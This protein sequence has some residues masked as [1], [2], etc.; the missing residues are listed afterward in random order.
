MMKHLLLLLALLSTAPHTRAQRVT[1]VT[2]EQQ[3]QE[4]LIQYHLEA[5][6]PL[7][8]QLYLSI[9]RGTRWE[10]PLKSCTGDVGPNVPPGTDKRIRWEVLKEREL[11]GD[12]IVFKVVA[13]STL[14][15]RSNMNNKSIIYDIDGNAY[16]TVKI[17]KRIWMADNLRTRRY[18]NGD[19]IPHTMND[20]QWSSLDIGSWCHYNND[21]KYDSLYA[22]LYN[23]YVIIDPRKVCPV[24][25]HVPSDAEWKTLTDYLAEKEVRIDSQS[26]IDRARYEEWLI[27]F[28]QLGGSRSHDG[29]C[30]AADKASYWWSSSNYTSVYAWGRFH[31][32]GM[33]SVLRY[34]AY[35]NVGLSIRCIK[36]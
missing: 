35:K 29:F 10:G 25:W 5:D 2:A 22:K 12:E 3:G 20:A 17:G 18:R 11:V 7:E 9:D 26:N 21:S 15:K 36:D 14:I 19:S 30:Y 33:N 6:G 23:W 16:A 34:N 31:E 27:F 4:L 13:T 8:V 28:G 32:K 1:N 24:G